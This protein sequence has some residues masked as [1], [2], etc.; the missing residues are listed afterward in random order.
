M[1]YFPQPI[2]PCLTH[3][4][5]LPGLPD[6]RR[7]DHET[8]FVNAFLLPGRRDRALAQLRSSRKR[9]QF[10]NRLP[11]VQSFFAPDS[12]QPLP[13][14][15]STPDAVHDLLRALGAPVRCYVISQDHRLDAKEMQLHD[16]L[17]SVMQKECAS[18][19]SCLPG[20]LG[21]YEAAGERFVL[22]VT[23]D[24]A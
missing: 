9:S 2:N 10:L 15:V 17:A 5:L 14:G 8:A 13:E 16:A 1:S 23:P 20:R 11:Q 21:F 6:L 12:L 7:T 4:T 3:R 22:A 24:Q 19:V 18:V